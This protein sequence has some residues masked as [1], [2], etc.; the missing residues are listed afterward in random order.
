MASQKY[1]TLGQGTLS[2]AYTAGATSLVLG[3]GQGATFPSA[4]DFVVALNDPPS[5]FLKCTARTSDTLTV[6]TGAVDGTTASNQAI[7]VTVTEVITAT[8]LDGIRGDQSQIGAA[9]SLPATS[10]AHKGD[11]YQTSDGPIEFIYGGSAWQPYGPKQPLILPKLTDFTNLSGAATVSDTGAGV[12]VSGSAAQATTY[13]RA[14]PVS[15]PYTVTLGVQTIIVHENFGS[16]FM[17][18]M[19]A[20][21][22]GVQLGLQ[23]NSG[24]N[25]NSTTLVVY[26]KDSSLALIS[27]PLTRGWTNFAGVAWLRIKDDGTTRSF[28]VGIGPN[29]FATVLAHPSGTWITPTLVGFTVQGSTNVPPLCRIIHWQQG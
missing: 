19:D 18:L 23:Y 7:G 22:K 29:D 13:L 5:F 4:G 15:T 27:S 6:A 1:T 28:Q 26:E 25:T 12:L 14:V 21:H 16:V 2:T 3:T 8:V 9:A 10:E 20:T 11:R 24:W 17:E